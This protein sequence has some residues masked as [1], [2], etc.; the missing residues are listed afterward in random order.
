MFEDCHNITS[1]NL[2][3]FDTR[4]VTDMTQMINECYDLT[5]LNMSNWYLNSEVVVT[6][7]FTDTNILTRVIM[8]NSDYNSVNKIISVLPTRTT[9]SMGA[10]NVAGVDDINQVNINDAKTKFWIINNPEKIKSIKINNKNINKIY[11]GLLKIKK[12]YLG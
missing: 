6:D 11:K 9:D 1:L 10:L 8:N 2:S 7:M 3:N 12:I 5:E 4:N